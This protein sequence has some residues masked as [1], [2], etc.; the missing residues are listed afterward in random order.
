MTVTKK[1]FAAHDYHQIVAQW[2]TVSGVNN[3]EIVDVYASLGSKSA[4]SLMIESYDGPSTIRLNVCQ[5]I[6][7]RQTTDN[8]WVADAGFYTKPLMVDEVEIEKDD[9]LIPSGAIFSM[10]DDIPVKDFKVIT[11]PSGTK[12]TFA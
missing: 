2:V 9:I 3:G 6:H 4:K 1:S 5:I 11:M 12:I 7:K 10:N 8:P